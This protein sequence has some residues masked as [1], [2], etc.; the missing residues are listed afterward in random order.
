[1]GINKQTE[2]VQTGLRE[3]RGHAASWLNST[4]GLWAQ[5][6][7]LYYLR[8]KRRLTE[9]TTS[10][11]YTTACAETDLQPDLLEYPMWYILGYNILS[12]QCSLA[13]CRAHCLGNPQCRSMDFRHPT[14]QCST[15]TVTARD[16]PGAWT[17]STAQEQLYYYQRICV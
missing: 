14:N 3:C 4:D 16:V 9:T 1:M 2:T 8:A 10:A 13:D 6:S 17:Q 5:G 7:K 11:D 12:T 15:A